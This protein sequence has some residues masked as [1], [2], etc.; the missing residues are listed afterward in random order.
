[1]KRYFKFDFEHPVLHI[2]DDVQITQRTVGSSDTVRQL[3]SP[4]HV[5]RLI[6]NNKKICYDY[7]EISEKEANSIL[8]LRELNR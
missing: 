3:Q 5:Y 4:E 8:M 1:M 2:F 7:Q 6:R